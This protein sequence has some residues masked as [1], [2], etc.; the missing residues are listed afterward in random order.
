MKQ[1]Y[2]DIHLSIFFFFFNIDE[3]DLTDLRSQSVSTDLDPSQFF[4]NELQQAIRE[5]RN[6][7]ENVVDTQRNDMQNRYQLLYNELVIQQ[8]RPGVD[9]LLTE[10]Q[11][12]QEERVRSQILQTQNE[13]AFLK[14]RNQDV[15]NRIDDLTRRLQ[16]LKQEGG[17][18][19]LKVDR[20]IADARARLDQAQRDFEAVTNMKTSL[21]KEITTYRDLLESKKDDRFS[22]EYQHCVYFFLLRSKWSSWIC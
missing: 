9:S 18:N 16:S 19:Q 21:E 14:A 5:I 8:N 6:D 10:Q 4:R 2:F 1:I 20:E 13:G 11:R 12:R 22:F 15:R 3:A 7:Y 17:A